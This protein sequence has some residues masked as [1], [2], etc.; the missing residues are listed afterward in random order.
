MSTAFELIAY[1]KQGDPFL[2]DMGYFCQ[3]SFHQIAAKGAYFITRLPEGT[4]VVGMDAKRLNIPGSLRGLRK[5]D[6]TVH[7]WRVKV[8]CS[9]PV[10]GRLVAARID[11]GKAGERRRKLRKSC[12]EQGRTPSRD[13]LTMC[14]WVVVF[15]K[16]EA[17][18][19]VAESVA[20]LY[21]A[22]WMVEIF[23]PCA[24]LRS[25]KNRSI[26]S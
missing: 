13:Q 16:V 11:S 3:R 17:D 20:Q 19:M 25:W 23:F 22:R 26:T 14:E 6:R 24:A 7:E 21:R 5:T 10:E 4:A 8:G 12:S 18:M 2:R 1:L 15:T 9:N